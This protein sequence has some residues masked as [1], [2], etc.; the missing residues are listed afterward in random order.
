MPA[1]ISQNIG[2]IN[3]PYDITPVGPQSMRN[4]RSFLRLT[5]RRH[6]QN[7][8]TTEMGMGRK[9]TAIFRTDS[10]G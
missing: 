4:Y 3:G 9:L 7:N 5:N 1:G 6:K 8:R 2:T 10:K